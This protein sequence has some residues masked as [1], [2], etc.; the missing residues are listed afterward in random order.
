MFFIKM[1]FLVLKKTFWNKKHEIAHNG[2]DLALWRQSVTVQPELSLSKGTLVDAI[3][4]RS[5]LFVKPD[6]QLNSERED[7]YIFVIP[8]RI[9]RK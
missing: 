4:S 9:A 7:E 1:Y 6:M 5:I 3:F 8:Q 2:Q